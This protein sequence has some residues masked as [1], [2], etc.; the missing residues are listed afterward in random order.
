MGVETIPQGLAEQT[1]VREALSRRARNIR[2]R[3][4]SGLVADSV[5]VGLKRAAI[6]H[7]ELPPSPF[8]LTVRLMTD[9][10]RGLL[11]PRDTRNLDEAEHGEIASRRKLA[12]LFP[13]SGYA[14]IDETSGR[15]C[16]AMWL[17]GAAQNDRIAQLEGLPLLE[18]HQ[19]LA[20]GAYVPPSY[21]GQRVMT[22][23]AMRA[24]AHAENLGA[25]EIVTFIGETNIPSIKGAVR[26]GFAPYMLHVRRHLAFGIYYFDRFRPID[27]SHPRFGGIFS[28]A[29]AA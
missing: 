29:A 26:G 14:V 21:R 5:Q 22:A 28:G 8:P 9:A 16:Y 2:R 25:S 15:P 1:S 6:R 4:A 17:I 18:A 13:E 10:D 20:E 12:A 23:A 7:H 19:V 27:G 3:L 11:L 24:L